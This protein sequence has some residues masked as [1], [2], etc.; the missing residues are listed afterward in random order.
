MHPQVVKSAPGNCPI[1]GMTLVKK[2][3]TEKK[4]RPNPR[5]LLKRP[6]QLKKLRFRNLK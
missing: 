3:L 4:R 5:P 6:P 2:T 1:C